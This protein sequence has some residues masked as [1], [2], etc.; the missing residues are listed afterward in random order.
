MCAQW[1]P[2]VTRPGRE[3]CI[4][5]GEAQLSTVLAHSIDALGNPFVAVLL[6][7]A[8]AAVLLF[9]SRAS[10][11]LVNA[12][13]A[14]AGIALAAISL[15]MR[16]AGATLA[17]WAYKSFVPVGLKPFAIAL[18]GGFVVMYTLELVRYAGLHRYSRPASVRR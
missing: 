11:R 5:R 18:A 13:A 12:Q 9:S 6:G 1:P 2:P 3:E 8:L 15:F 4:A 16:L 10:M 17:L 14:E 7:L